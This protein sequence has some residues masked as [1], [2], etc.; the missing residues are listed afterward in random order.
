MRFGHKLA[1][2]IFSTGAIVLV[3]VSYTAY[4]YNRDALIESQRR[5]T[6][7]IADLVS[8]NMEQL[9]IE[10]TKI[11]LTLANT[12]LIRNALDESNSTYATLTEKNRKELINQFDSRWK[13]IN[14]EKDPFVFKYTDN[15][16]SRYFKEQQATLRDEYGEI[17]LT[18]KF[19]ALV[20]STSKLS[21]F[22]HGHKYWWTGSYNSG[23]SSVFFDDRGYDDSVSGYVLGIVVP[24]RYNNGIAG[25]L[26]CN[27]N[28]LGAI[29]RL[30]SSAKDNLIGDFKLVR[31]GG[32]IVFEEGLEPLS[33]KIPK[34][35]SEK[36]N[37]KYNGSL[38]VKVD[39]K[40]WLVG[41][42][43]IKLT[44]GKNGY[45]FGGSRKSIDHKKGN[46][47]ESWFIL[48]FREMEAVLL[49]A[50]ES[51][52]T[53][54]LT[55]ILVIFI[56][57][58]LSFW[59]GRR[60]AQPLFTLTGQIESVAR[61]DFGVK[62]QSKR[63]DEFGILARSINRMSEELLSTTTSIKSLEA[64]VVRRKKSESEKEALIGELKKTLKHVRMLRGLLPI[65]SYCKKIRDDNG[66]WNQVE[67]YI[68]QYAKVE[69]S[70][71]IC[72][73]CAK[74]HYPDVD[75]YDD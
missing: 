51:I 39:G 50:V 64:E 41:C 25:I 44:S 69:F 56:L 8:Q 28:V 53:I 46:K 71:S 38:F 73:T 27:L 48:N 32:A 5:Y 57:T 61:G 1:L 58:L 59:I 70:H 23:A 40:E 62:V 31:S 72:P 52:K 67:S 45:R 36:L 3:L 2:T 24:V 55:L 30:I 54:A 26:K 13:G 49:P 74:I 10:K 60:V 19:G 37:E 7:S 66:Y 17:F 33:T 6:I 43:E 63:M 14:D 35:I 29:N 34:L 42:S 65:C 16:V 20:A 15:R 4:R 18:N 9:L 47:G 75:I 21:T 22:A 11:A 68:Q 12:P